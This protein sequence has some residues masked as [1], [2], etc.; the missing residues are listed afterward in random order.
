MA[1]LV[2]GPIAK[3]LIDRNRLSSEDPHGELSVGI[4][5]HDVNPVTR[6]THTSIMH[7]MLALNVAIALGAVLHQ[8][9]TAIGLKL[10]LF[11][12]CLIMGIVLA[13]LRS[14]LFPRAAPLS[15]TPSLALISDLA[16]GTFLAMSLMALQL[17]TLAAMGMAIFVILAIQV[18]STVALVI[19]GLF[20]IMG[21]DYLAAVL[22]SGFAGFA[23]GATPTA[24]ANMT[25][26][27][28]HYGPA[29]IAF[30]VLPLVSAF[31][32]DLANA[33]VIQTI[34]NF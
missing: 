23:L 5:E 11:V 9:F 30:V 2:G 7:T 31:F 20:A 15:R 18:V 22:A 24:I 19:F 16:L 1:A 10:P 13:N 28:K 32:V 29:P 33:V 17:W 8:G 12:P 27:T 14:L 25:A 3:F 4:A 34:V 6:I 21:R 26:V